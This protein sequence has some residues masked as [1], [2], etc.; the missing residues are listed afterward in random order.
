MLHANLLSFLWKTLIIQWVN[1]LGLV[2]H[3]SVNVP[4]N[5]TIFQFFPNVNTKNKTE[6]M[7]NY[8][9]VH[10]IT[11]LRIICPYIRSLPPLEKIM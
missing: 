1:I 3:I 2:S 5:S 8:K 6:N 11:K 9:K 4:L 10:M 7:Y